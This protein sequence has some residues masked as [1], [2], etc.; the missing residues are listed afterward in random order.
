MLQIESLL[1]RIATFIDDI[2][3]VYEPEE[4]LE[5][6][7]ANLA[8]NTVLYA[9]S[10]LIVMVLLAILFSEKFPKI[11]LPLFVLMT[12]TLAGSTL[13][14]IG[15]TVYLNTSSFSG[16]PVHWHADVEFWACGNELELRDPTGFL[17]NKIGTATL[18]EHNDHRIHLEGV[19]VEGDVD[20]SLGKFMHVVG[21]A[22]TAQQ[23]VVPLNA[24]EDGEIFEDEEDGDGPAVTDATLVEPY[25]FDDPELG[26]V[27][28]F[29]D[30]D[31]CGDDFA[32]VQVFVYKY[33][34]DSKTYEQEKLDNPRD[35][36]IRD[37]PNVPPGDCIIFE[38]GPERDK[39]D[40]LCAQYG[41]R[42]IDR[43][44]QF[45]VEP[46]QKAIC[47]LT[48]TNFSEAA[49][50]PA[51][52]NSTVPGEEVAETLTGVHE[53]EA[54]EASRLACQ[55]ALASGESDGEQPAECAEYQELLE[56][57]PALQAEVDAT[58]T[59]PSDTELTEDDT[60]GEL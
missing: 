43:C 36:I 34:G 35:Y 50:L 12:L 28:N 31:T 57:D 32:D 60:E 39:T 7:I 56:N 47:E 40:K 17:S 49:T 11:K 46:N 38:F 59:T 10:A 44:E 6:T 45:G 1:T 15:S 42:D 25:I 23:L 14:L 52:A 13:T 2:P 21:G 26:K 3:G 55:D 27:A 29:R 9:A 8:M 58:V 30:G 48:Q 24:D 54:A 41:I 22:I 51:N 20:A 16:G 37:N 53:D 5:T 18:H 19:V 4:D 33:D